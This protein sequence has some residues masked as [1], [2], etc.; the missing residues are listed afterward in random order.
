ML[1]HRDRRGTT[2]TPRTPL[3][4][5]GSGGIAPFRAFPLPSDQKGSASS[6]PLRSEFDGVPNAAMHTSTA[7]SYMCLAAAF[8][9]ETALTNQ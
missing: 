1:F 3:G 4:P 5:E 2:N 9:V 8:G 6:R 7:G